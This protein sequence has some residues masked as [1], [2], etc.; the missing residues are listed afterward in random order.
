MTTGRMYRTRRV[1]R[2]RLM[3]RI[4]VGAIV[5]GLVLLTGDAFTVAVGLVL[6]AAGSAGVR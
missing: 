6:I 1:R 4:S 3:Y 2:T 5:A